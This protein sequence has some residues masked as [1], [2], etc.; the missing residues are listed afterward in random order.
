MAKFGTEAY[1]QQYL[2]VLGEDVKEQNERIAELDAWLEADD[3]WEHERAKTMMA[4]SEDI[5]RCR[6]ATQDEIRRIAVLRKRIAVLEKTPSIG[7]KRWNQHARHADVRNEVAVEVGQCWFPET[8]AHVDH[9]R[10]TTSVTPIPSNASV[11]PKNPVQ[12][13]KNKCG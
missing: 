10:N 4:L 7:V 1:V 2:G 9:G 8:N 6:V 11:A 3:I 5:E 12:C 13:N